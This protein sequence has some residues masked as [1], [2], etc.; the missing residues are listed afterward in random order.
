M[1]PTPVSG[2]LLLLSSAFKELF[3]KFSPM[4]TITIHWRGSPVEGTLSFLE[5]DP[6]LYF[7][8]FFPITLSQAFNRLCQILAYHNKIPL[9]G[10]DPRFAS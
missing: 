7:E 6:I 9:D 2:C 8:S 3:I 4:F 1:D 5:E 10:M